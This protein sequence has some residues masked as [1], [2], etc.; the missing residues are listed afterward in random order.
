MSFGKCEP[1]LRRRG[2]ESF[3]RVIR[4]CDAVFASR[5]VTFCLAS[6]RVLNLVAC[7]VL[8]RLKTNNKLALDAVG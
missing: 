7:L 2:L 8:K 6:L 5:F 1:E 3:L 4:S